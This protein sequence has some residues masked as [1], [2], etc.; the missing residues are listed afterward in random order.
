VKIDRAFRDGRLFGAALGDP[1]TWQVWLT[2]LCSAFAL[3]L[4][5]EQLQ[6]FAMIAGGRPPPSKLVRE[7]WIIAGRRSGKS[8]IAALIAVFS[9]LFAKHRVAPGERPMVLVIAGSVDQARL[10]FGY[11]KGFLEASPVLAK[12]VVAT[13]RHEIELKNGIV[14]GVHSNSFRT[15][16]R[17]NAS[18]GHLR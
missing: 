8:R 13:S 9:A 1:A 3:P 2:I 15:N 5:T 6:T 16:Q 4:T 18:G 14:V 10:V 11:V 7:L 17:Q 12:E